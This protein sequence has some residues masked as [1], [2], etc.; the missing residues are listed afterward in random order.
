MTSIEIEADSGGVRLAGTLWRP[1]GDAVAGVL[2]HPGSG[3]SDR[4]NDVFFPPIREHLL[5]AGIAV[6]SFDKRGVGGS[7]G[8]WLEAGIEAQTDDLLAGLAVFRAESAPGLPTGL[9]GHSQGAWVIVE[10]ASR[11]VPVAF[12]IPSSGGA[13][14]PAQ[15]ERYSLTSKLTAEQMP[16]ALAAYDAVIEVMRE[17]PALEAGL[18]ELDAAGV[19]YRELPGLEFAFDNEAVW[20]LFADI[21]GYDPAPALS[22][23]TAPVLGLFGAVDKVTPPG[24]SAEALRA[25]VRPELLDVEVFPEG[26]HR[27]HHGDPPRFVDG[28]LDRI[29]LFV[30]EACRVPTRLG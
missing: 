18:K 8:S 29:T 15:Q 6:C 3:P 19:S 25:A 26:D 7:G 11:G 1:D 10:A 21:C 5:A 20:R 23:I 9:F 12:V 13:V 22:R 16:A 27:L 30:L 4:D 2:M 17:R 24:E 14:V 28:Y